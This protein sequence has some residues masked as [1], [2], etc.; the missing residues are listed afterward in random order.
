[1]ASCFRSLIIIFLAAFCQYQWACTEPDENGERYIPSERDHNVPSVITGYNLLHIYRIPNLDT[2]CYG[3]VT[4][5][6]YCYR[7]SNNAGS[8]QPTF[9]WTVLILEDAGS[10]NLMINSIYFI[11]N[12]GA[13]SCTSS[14]DQVTCCD[15]INVNRFDLPMNFAFGVTEETVIMLLCWD[16]LMHFHSIGWIL[17]YLTRLV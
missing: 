2:S 17:Y 13:L 12:H 8:G 16:L 10:N 11:S 5:I 4:S 1:M 3:P 6:E 7:Y 9:N 15:M 14:G